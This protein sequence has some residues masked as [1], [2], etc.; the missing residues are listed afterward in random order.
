MYTNVY[1]YIYTHIYMYIYTCICMSGISILSAQ[2]YNQTYPS[3]YPMI[4]LSEH[5][6]TTYVCV[7][8]P[9]VPK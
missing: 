1:I 6:I 2:I 3:N 5:P 8:A 7:L 4:T 9:T